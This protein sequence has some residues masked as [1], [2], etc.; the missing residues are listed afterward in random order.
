MSKK[1]DHS[2]FGEPAMAL[3]ASAQHESCYTNANDAWIM[4]SGASM[5]ITHRLDFLQD[6]VVTVILSVQRGRV[7]SLHTNNSGYSGQFLLANENVISSSQSSSNSYIPSFLSLLLRAEPYSTSRYSQS[8]QPQNVIGIDSI[9]ELAARLLFSAV[10]WTRHIPYF[11]ELQVTNQVALLRLVWSE[12]FVL[13]A[14][15][16]S[17]PLNVAPLLAAAGLHASPMAA[18]KVV[19]FMDHIRIFQEQVEKLKALRVDS[20]EYSCLK[21]IVLF[22]TDACGLSDVAHIESLQEKAQ[23]ALEEYCRT[24]YP[25]QLTRFGKLLLRLPSLRAVSSQVIEQL[26]FVR[27]VG[28]TPIQTLIRDM[29]LSGSSFNWP[30]V[31]SSTSF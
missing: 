30:Y 1:D 4:D 14:S 31:L 22:T 28:K 10:E 7:P 16:C 29:L 21:A 25:S 11:P 27:L 24:Q 2:N 8:M 15:Q 3:A 18:D 9:C 17:M 12:L 26:F 13:N 5:H 6:S 19:A 23:C 20:A